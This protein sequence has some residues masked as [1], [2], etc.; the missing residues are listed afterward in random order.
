MGRELVSLC[1]CVKQAD[2]LLLSNMG[3]DLI[4][5]YLSLSVCVYPS[6]SKPDNILLGNM[7]PDGTY[8]SLSSLP[9]TLFSNLLSL[10]PPSSQTYSLSLSLFCSSV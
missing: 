3:P 4:Y 10:L 5:L 8:P 9:A 2:I 6:L 1:V 7:G